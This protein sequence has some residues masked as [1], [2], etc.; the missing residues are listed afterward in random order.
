MDDFSSG[1]DDNFVT[2]PIPGIRSNLRNLE[3][4]KP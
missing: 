3:D 1:I 2:K 4:K